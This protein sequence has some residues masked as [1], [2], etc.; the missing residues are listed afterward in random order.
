MTRK[1]Y[2]D[3][4]AQPAAL[5]PEPRQEPQPLEPQVPPQPP[6]PPP[7]PVIVDFVSQSAAT[8]LPAL[9]LAA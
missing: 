2:T 1:K 6:P 8:P 3:E 5:P 7:G 4:E 9:S